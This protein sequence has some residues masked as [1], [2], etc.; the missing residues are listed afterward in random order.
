MSP[1]DLVC[2]GHVVREMIRFP[3]R[4]SGPVLGS[5]SAYASVAAAR[6]GTRTAIVTRIGPDMP[7]ALLEPLRQTGVDT[8][9][10]LVG[11]RTTASELIYDRDGGKEIRYPSKAEPLTASDVPRAW[12]GCRMIYVCTMDHDVEPADLAGVASLGGMSAVDLG[13]YGGVHMSRARRE[14]HPSL[15]ALACDAAS[16]FAIVKASDEDAVAIFGHADLEKAAD[17]LLAC[18]PRVLLLT[19]GAK[20]VLVCTEEGRLTV[21][22]LPC[23]VLDK[24][25]GG[26]TSMAGFLT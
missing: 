7:A 10:I 6:Q 18:G 25:G 12:H 22:A 13:G 24:T 23:A 21:Q 4:T 26:D 9:G 8:G 17:E 19:A 14:A 15:R 11:A 5:P 20:G 16:R 1:P 3:D 2:V